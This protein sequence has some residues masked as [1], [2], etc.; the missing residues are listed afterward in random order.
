MEHLAGEQGCARCPILA[1]SRS[2]IVHG[3]GD[4]TAQIVFVGEA[5]GR[6]GADRTGVPFSG[7]KSGRALQRILI[8]LGLME[9]QAPAER[10]RL[11]CYVTNVVRCCP[12]GNRTPT[13]QEQANCAAFLDAELGQ[14]DPL[15]IVPVGRL[16]LQA[17]GLRY[18]GTAPRAIRNVHATPLL[19]GQRVIVPLIHPSR[20]ARAQVEA[21]VETMRRVLGDLGVSTD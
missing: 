19:A 9:G 17:V 8:A 21:F 11:R 2:R 3:Y 15:V 18:L 20:I 4:P 14:L 16:A 5:P 12:P 10:P 1:A 6:H 7:D 13:R